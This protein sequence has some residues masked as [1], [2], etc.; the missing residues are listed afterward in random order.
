ME[1]AS[2]KRP[3]LPD[4]DEVITEV[5]RSFAH[6]MIGLLGADFF[7]AMIVDEVQP[8]GRGIALY[9]VGTTVNRIPLEGRSPTIEWLWDQALADGSDTGSFAEIR[10]WRERRG[11]SADFYFAPYIVQEMSL[12]G[13]PPPSES[14]RLFYK[15]HI[16]KQKLLGD[17]LYTDPK[18]I[19]KCSGGFPFHKNGY[20]NA[21]WL[22]GI[23]GLTTERAE[24]LRHNIEA[25]SI[26]FHMSW[27][28]PE[29]LKDK[30]EMAQTKAKREAQEAQL[31][32]FQ[33]A[34]LLAMTLVEDVFQAYGS[35]VHVTQMLRPKDKVLLMKYRNPAFYI[36]AVDNDDDAD[37]FHQNENW[38][39]RHNWDVSLIK[40]SPEDSES[41]RA[42][43][44]CILLSFFGF[45]DLPPHS[46]EWT[47]GLDMPWVILGKYHSKIAEL[48]SESF[49]KTVEKVT[50]P[51]LSQDW[52]HADV[53]A[54][55]FLKGCFHYPFKDALARSGSGR[56]T[57]PSPLTG[58]LLA[59]WAAE[60]G[61]KQS[62]DSQTLKFLSIS[63]S[64]TGNG[65]PS[66]Y[67]LSA[68]H[69][70]YG[71]AQKE[72]RCCLKV[73]AAEGSRSGELIV[74]VTLSGCTS[75]YVQNLRNIRDGLV[76]RYSQD[77]PAL[78]SSKDLESQ[79]GSLPGYIEIIC[80]HPQVG[81]E[82]YSDETS[83]TVRLAVRK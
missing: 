3:W 31:S 9:S 10:Q 27:G 48:F 63:E 75:D 49:N 82:F 23:S 6:E 30:A 13:F 73:T 47:E 11:E 41:F 45:G 33:G 24:E 16:K 36:P 25:F 61:G 8:L 76:S 79:L 78:L 50:S 14:A 21:A 20:Y 80:R 7:S 54:F 1:V 44:S 5:Y 22:I 4:N 64:T 32:H 2:Y 17:F 77:M 51:G 57:A 12:R 52:D 71:Y 42:Q 53:K 40:R 55:T 74:S 43:V 19:S 69:G 68:L 15:D 72:Q 39:F 46:I 26:L 81:F 59:I 62:V 83:A 35:A 18:L 66:K 70:I 37:T 67:V 56:L 38:R 58:P 28:Y 60:Y 29:L 34:S 65:W